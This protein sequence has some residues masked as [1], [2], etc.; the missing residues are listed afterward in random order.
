MINPTRYLMNIK[1]P[2]LDAKIFA[3]SLLNH[4]V[5]F[6]YSKNLLFQK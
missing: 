3:L 4:Y 6:Y 2:E 1:E 5:K